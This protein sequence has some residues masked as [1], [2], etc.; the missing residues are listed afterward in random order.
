MGMRHW[1]GTFWEYR[2]SLSTPFED[3]YF[4]IFRK[5]AVDAIKVDSTV[6]FI[7]VGNDNKG[8]AVI[9]NTEGV[10]LSGVMAYVEKEYKTIEDMLEN[11]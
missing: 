6:K 1:H 3:I 9:E 10:E 5:Y 4:G 2:S 7:V 11:Y 8:Y